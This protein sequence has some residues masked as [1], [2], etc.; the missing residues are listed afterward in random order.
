MNNEVKVLLKMIVKNVIFILPIINFFMFLIGHARLAFI[1]SLGLLV[2]TINFILSGIIIEK[3]INSKRKILNY[4]FP[5]S[6]LLRIITIIVI[7]YPFIYSIKKL[8]FYMLGIISFFIVLII[9]WLKMQ[10]GVSK[11]RYTNL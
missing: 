6:Y 5:L 1:F 2:A 3:T 8:L 9:T 11:W 10:R 4:L 7:A